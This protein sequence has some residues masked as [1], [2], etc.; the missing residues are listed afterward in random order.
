MQPNIPTE[1]ELIAY[2]LHLIQM[3]LPYLMASFLISCIARIVASITKAPDL[4]Y[5]FRGEDDATLSQV[6]LTYTLLGP[7]F[8]VIAL[9]VFVSAA[10]DFAHDCFQHHEKRKNDQ[11]EKPKRGGLA[12]GSDGEFFFSNEDH[13][14]E[15]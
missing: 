12:I 14:H 11:I 9:V 8:V 13:S 15:D 7:V 4:L 6:A 1:G 10:L 2:A 3:A 5:F